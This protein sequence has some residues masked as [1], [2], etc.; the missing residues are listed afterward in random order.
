MTVERINR[1]P[2][3]QAALE[4]SGVL[5]TLE[6]L[7]NVWRIPTNKVQWLSVCNALWQAHRVSEEFHLLESAEMLADMATLAGIRAEMEAK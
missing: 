6:L 4:V 5:N 1:T 7:Q 3:L 2:A